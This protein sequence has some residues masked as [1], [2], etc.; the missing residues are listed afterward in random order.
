[1]IFK[2]FAK[3]NHNVGLAEPQKLRAIK[4]KVVLYF[5]FANNTRLFNSFMEEVIEKT[6]T[7]VDESK[8]PLNRV[9]GVVTAILMVAG[10]IIGTGVFKKVVPMAQTGLSEFFI[11]LAWLVAGL[12]VLLGAFTFA[13]L[14]K[15]TTESGGTYEYFR[16]AFGDLLAFLEGWGLFVIIGSG[17]VAAIAFIFAQSVNTMITIPNLFPQWENLT[18]FHSVQPFASSGIKLFAVITIFLLTY[19]NYRGI[20]NSALLSNVITS[21]KILG[22]LFLILIGLIAAVPASS[23]SL[24]TIS[25]PVQSVTPSLTIFLGA[26]LSAF[27]AYDGFTNVTAIAG[28]IKNPT[29]NI[30]IAVITAV[31]LVIILYVAVNFAFMRVMPVQELAA[32]GENKIAAAEVTQRITGS[33]GAY[34]ISLLIMLSSFGALN[35][36]ILF[37]SR[38]YYRMAQEKVFFRGAAKVHPRFRT[39]YNALWY[40]MI[41]SCLLTLSGTYD[42]LTN[43]VIFTGFAFYMLAAVA[44]FIL[45]RKKII[46]E[47]VPGFPWAPTLFIVFTA[48]FLIGILLSYS[49][50]SLTGT[51]LLLTGIPVYYYFKIKNRKGKLR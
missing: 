6:G 39:P 44:L 18:I 10:N 43:M 27:W 45:K 21:A 3:V 37:Y 32:L 22:I 15:A 12:I 28:E 51:G 9:V 8:I 40:S 2:I 20:R 48:I 36:I 29:R 33:K 7:F 46:N 35:I 13:G 25:N 49:R 34:F 38:V 26:M 5:F 41:W 42:I 16:L 31:S 4:R 17:S 23:S 14:S 50:Q 1:M 19:F 30:P 47:S 24:A 11:L